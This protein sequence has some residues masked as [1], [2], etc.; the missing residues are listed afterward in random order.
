[1]ER[2]LVFV[3]HAL[4]KSELIDVYVLNIHTGVYNFLA[5]WWHSWTGDEF[6]ACKETS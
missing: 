2:L 5:K 3:L 4:L 6:V 1:M